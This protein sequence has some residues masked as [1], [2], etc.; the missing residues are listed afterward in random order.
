MSGIF[1]DELLSFGLLEMGCIMITD[2]GRLDVWLDVCCLALA[3]DG[4]VDI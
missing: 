2:F 1:G 4:N 3:L